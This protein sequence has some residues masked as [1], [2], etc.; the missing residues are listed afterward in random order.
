MG[1]TKKNTLEIP[2]PKEIEIFVK[3]CYK[4]GGA[5]PMKE[6]VEC[7]WHL[8]SIVGG[9]QCALPEGEKK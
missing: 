1:V 5:F 4:T 2:D 8:W 9:S 6:C 3:H 7:E